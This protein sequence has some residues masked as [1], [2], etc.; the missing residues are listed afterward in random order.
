M[1]QPVQ[2]GADHCLVG[3]VFVRVESK[4]GS[5]VNV[6]FEPANIP[7]RPVLIFLLL[8]KVLFSSLEVL[9]DL[10]GLRI[11]GFVE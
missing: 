10:H 7:P 11:G 1:D 5:L 6:D 4:L 9:V 2:A 3:N 8:L